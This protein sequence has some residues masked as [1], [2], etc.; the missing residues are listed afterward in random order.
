MVKYVSI[1]FKLR[2]DNVFPVTVQEYPDGEKKY[3]STLS[4]TS[5]LDEGEWSKPHHGQFISGQRDLLHIFE[6]AAW[7]QGQEGGAR[8][9][10]SLQRFDPLTVQ[11]VASRYT[12][13]AIQAEI[14]S[15]L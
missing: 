10:S 12:D 7:A 14:T 2:K 3:S 5:A 6:E 9:M 4:L 15:S 11:P 1:S 13:Y 8:K